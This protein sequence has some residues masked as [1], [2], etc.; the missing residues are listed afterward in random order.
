[1]LRIFGLAHLQRLSMG[2]NGSSDYVHYFSSN[3]IRA[4]EIEQECSSAV[5]NPEPLC[6]R[7][8]SARSVLTK[9]KTFFEDILVLGL[10][11]FTILAGSFAHSMVL[12]VMVAWWT[13]QELKQMRIQKSKYISLSN[14]TD[15]AVVLL[16]LFL[17]FV[18][19]RFVNSVSNIYHQFMIS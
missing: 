11:S 10:G 9:I 5:Q 14:C 19:T 16:T 3:E 18:P 13:L 15:L 8:G 4:Y 7:R 2:A 12:A 17:L 1:M 6:N